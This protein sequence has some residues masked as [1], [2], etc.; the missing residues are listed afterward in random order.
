MGAT[1]EIPP[2]PRRRGRPR[3]VPSTSNGDPRAEILAAA[4]TLIAR[5]GLSGASTRLIAREA[6]LQ[7]P[8]VFYY[9]SSKDAI[10]SELLDQVVEPTLHMLARIQRA[11]AS[12]PASLFALTYYDTW[13]MV[14]TERNRGLIRVLP[15]L[16]RE[17]F[18]AYWRKV[19]ELYS[20]YQAIVAG[21][22]RQAMFCDGDPVISAALIGS[23]VERAASLAADNPALATTSL[24]D[25]VVRAAIRTTLVRLS[26]L[27]KIEREGHALLGRSGGLSVR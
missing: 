24:V 26:G 9:F 17:R 12:P 27:R 7:Q 22:Q 14:C 18:P 16:R 23:L 10:I 6:G 2:T 15:D 20:G 1:G 11:K 4:A 3:A 8:S 19:E 5:T 13:N 25:E 21:G